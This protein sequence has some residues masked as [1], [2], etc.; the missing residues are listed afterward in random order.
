MARSLTVVRYNVNEPLGW[1]VEA[2]SG[3]TLVSSSP[4]S[5][6]RLSCFMWLECDWSGI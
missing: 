2:R 1:R 4:P 3:E 5:V 6:G